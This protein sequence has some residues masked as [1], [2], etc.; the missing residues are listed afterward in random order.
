MSILK[1]VSGKVFLV[2]GGGSGLGAATARLLASEG[3]KLAIFDI[4]EKLGGAVAEE[5]KGIFCKTNVAEEESVKNAIAATVGAYGSLFGAVNCA[6]IAPASKVLG[7]KGVH[8]LDTFSKVI[9]VNLIGTFNVL[10]LAAEQMA[11]NEVVGLEDRGV[12]INTA[13]VAAY[14]GQVGQAAYAASKG[15]V[16]GLGLPCARELAAHH[17]RVNTIAPGIINTPMMASFPQATQDAL[18]KSV[19]FPPRLGHPDEYAA[20]VHHLIINQ[21]MNG[22][23]IRFD[24]AIRMGS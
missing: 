21:Y 19:P 7:R 10:R 6:G 12:I 15:G 22:E 23:V 5:V 14:E 11:K 18:A 1:S 17:I 13:S 3:A 8:S 9:N 2:T 4:D 20:L 24:G 16:V